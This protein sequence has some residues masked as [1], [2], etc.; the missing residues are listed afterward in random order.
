VPYFTDKKAIEYALTRYDV[1]HDRQADNANTKKERLDASGQDAFAL[2]R[3][4][5]ADHEGYNE[6]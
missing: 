2:I 1:L 5:I 3:E 6:E 4:T